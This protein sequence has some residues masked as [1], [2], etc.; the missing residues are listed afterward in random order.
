MS[1]A[2]QAPVEIYFNESGK[3]SGV[4]VRL[5]VVAH[6]G[7]PVWLEFEGS[8]VD[9]F[10][11]YPEDADTVHDDFTAISAVLFQEKHDE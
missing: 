1:D 8:N 2:I 6:Q 3:V 4:H 5:D 9:M 7:E 10:A 11:L